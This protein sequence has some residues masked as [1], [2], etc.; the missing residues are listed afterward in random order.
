MIDVKDIGNKKKHLFFPS[1]RQ[2]DITCALVSQ[3]CGREHGLKRAALK[4]LEITGKRLG[5]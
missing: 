5:S 3:A 1:S 4:Y 2:R